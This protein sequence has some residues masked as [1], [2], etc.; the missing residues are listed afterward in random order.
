[1]K[2]TRLFLTICALLTVCTAMH[3]K[4]KTAQLDAESISTTWNQIPDSLFLYQQP[5]EQQWWQRFND[6]TLNKLVDEVLKNNFDLKQAA[7]RVDQAKAAMRVA[8]GGFYPTINLNASYTYDKNVTVP[9]ATAQVGSLGADVSWEID[10]IGAVRNR[11]KSKKASYLASQEEYNAVMTALVAQTVQTYVQ[12]R[13]YQWRLQVIESNLESQKETMEITEARFH[14]GLASALEVA[15]AKSIYYA[16]EA[17]VPA[18]ES[19]ISSAINQMG[20]LLGQVPWSVSEALALP[21]GMTELTPNM[22]VSVGIPAEVLRQRPDVRAAEK[23]IDAKAA[24]VGAHVADW[25]PRFFVTGQFGYASTNFQNLFDNG[26]MYW[27]VAPAMQWTIFSGTTLTGNIQAAKASLEEAVNAYN[28]TVLTALQEVDDAMTHY[29]HAT[30]E[31]EAVQKA[32]EQAKLTNDL[33]LDLYKKGLVDFQNV[34]DAQRS[35]LQYEDNL[36]QAK[37][38]VSLSLVQLYRALGGEWNNEQ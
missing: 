7:Y 19:N 27:Q 20:I 12:L 16:T 14:T 21:D 31:V 24:M 15:Q 23:N 10:I 29:R 25:L 32:F 2:T 33:A 6:A 5:L 22:L 8:Q 28:N 36:V 38:S 34:L 35:L 26:N 17:Q 37:S 18:M 9:G 11:A 1:M 3:A 30:V 4:P 13:T